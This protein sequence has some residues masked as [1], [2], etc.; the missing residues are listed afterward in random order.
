M[1]AFLNA[2]KARKR[3]FKRCCLD[4]E[5]GSY[6]EAKHIVFAWRVTALGLGLIF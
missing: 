4:E 1:N 2:L 6:G 3:R 5:G